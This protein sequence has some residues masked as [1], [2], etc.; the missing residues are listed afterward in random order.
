MRNLT[1]TIAA[2]CLTLLSSFGQQQP[3]DVAELT[4][5]VSAFGTEELYYGFAQGDQIVLNF[6]EMNG[7]E[8]KELDVIELP[9]NSKFMDYKT[10][11]I[12]DK[13]ISVNKKAVYKFV[14]SNS[15][16]AGR[17]CK[18]KIQRIPQSETTIS[19]NTGWRW[20][21]LYDTS[22]VAYTRDSI[23]GYDTTYTPYTKKEL[24]KIDTSFTQIME[25][26]ERVHSE[27][28]LDSPP[29][30][31]INVSLPANVYT[32]SSYNPYYSEENICWSYFIG[33]G[34]EGKKAFDDAN[35][36]LGNT[37]SGAAALIPGYGTL[38][39]LAIKGITNISIPSVGDNV[40][41][42]FKAIVNG[43]TLTFDSGDGITASGRNAKYLNGGFTIK[44]VNDNLRNGIDVTVKV[45][46]MREKKTWEDISY[47][48]QNINPRKVTLH[49]QRRVIK[50][51]EVRTN[52][53]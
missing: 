19:F 9:S 53:Q 36:S 31:Y 32:P 27:T 15:A 35:R 2:F 50:S 40:K 45:V 10:V 49:K 21:T 42:Y 30:S 11:K 39:S 17:I 48:K 18:V 41:Y 24:K 7:K 4:L 52:E 1:L 28:N 13:K 23:V 46:V 6:E 29:E 37:L 33:V 25:K 5:K 22:Y 8:L 12:V 44:L 47:K 14:F 51:T 3:V 38:A 34:Q 16:M 20:L 43:Q 26:V